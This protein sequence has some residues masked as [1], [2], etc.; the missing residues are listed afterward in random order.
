MRK[1]T[2]EFDGFEVKMSISKFL[3]RKSHVD[4]Q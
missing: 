4:D 2:V 1:M 3:K